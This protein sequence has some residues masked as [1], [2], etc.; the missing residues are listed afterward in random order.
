MSMPARPPGRPA[1]RGAWQG[2]RA[3]LGYFATADEAALNIARHL[4]A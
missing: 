3:N 4:A 2:K 1:G